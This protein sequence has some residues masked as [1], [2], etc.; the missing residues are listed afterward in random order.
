MPDCNKTEV[1]VAEWVRMCHREDCLT[2]YL[3]NYNNLTENHLTCTEFIRCCP[4]GAIEI[5][6]RWSDEHPIK[7]KTR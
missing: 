6:Q 2:C 3:S 5:V 7:I 4:Q 1:F